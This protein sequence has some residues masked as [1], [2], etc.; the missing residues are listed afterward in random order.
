MRGCIALSLLFVLTFSGLRSNAQNVKA[1]F[2]STNLKVG[3]QVLLHLEMNVPANT[4]VIWPSLKDTLSGGV[5]IIK[6]FKPDSVKKGGNLQIRQ[7]ILV[8]SFDSGYHRIPPIAFAYMKDQKRDTLFSEALGL[9]VTTLPV[10][11]LKDILDIKPPLKPPFSILDYW[12][13]LAGALLLVLIVL[14]VLLIIKRKK[15]GY[16]FIPPKPQDP[17]YVVALRELDTLRSEKLWQT[18]RTKEYYTRLTDVIRTYIEKR[19]GINAMEMTSE[20]I[21][22]ELKNLNSESDEVIHLLDRMFSTSDLVKFAKAQPLPDEN[23]VNL[24]DA[25]QFVNNTKPFEQNP[26][27]N[28]GDDSN[29]EV[30]NSRK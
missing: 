30:S 3:D 20:E 19:F 26:G 18:N 29:N 23:E 11:S 6:A 24:L 1:A 25:Y 10:D 17:P 28:Q 14:T 2:D 13:Y 22:L 8:T 27:E 21:L 4:K 15:K 12:P 9:H 5:E 16:L 7:N